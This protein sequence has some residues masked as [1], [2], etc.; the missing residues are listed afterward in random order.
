MQPHARWRLDAVAGTQKSWMAIDQRRR[1][2]SFR[3]QPLVAVE[4]GGNGFE[5]PRALAETDGQILPVVGGDDVGKDVE[6]PG[7][8]RADGC[9]DVVGDAALVELAGD[10]LFRARELA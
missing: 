8:R 5:Q 3:D 9:V 7:A 4:I 1:Q 10:A 6:G 2:V